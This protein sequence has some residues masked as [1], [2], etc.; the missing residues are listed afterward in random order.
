LRERVDRAAS[1][2]RAAGNVYHLADV[3]QM[4]ALRA[5]RIGSDRDASDYASRA[6]PLVRQLDDRYLWMLLCHQVGC[7]ALFTGATEAARDAFHEQLK[8]CQDLVVMPAAAKGLAGLAA[9]ATVRDDLDRAARLCGAAVA[10]RY[11]EPIDA[12]EARLHT[13]FFEPARTR[14]GP[15]SWDAAVRDGGALSFHDAITYALTDGRAEAT[16]STSKPH[17]PV[18]H[19]H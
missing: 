8:L 1:L 4:A 6:I 16:D 19:A 13:S 2:L 14:R 3:F 12:I 7:A 9:V 10:L 5:L 17:V 18:G 15:D 11:G